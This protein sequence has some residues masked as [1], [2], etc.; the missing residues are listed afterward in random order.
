[1][2]LITGGGASTTGYTRKSGIIILLYFV[3][4]SPVG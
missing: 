3:L 2:I 1:M 4:T